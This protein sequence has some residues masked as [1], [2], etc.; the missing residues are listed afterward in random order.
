VRHLTGRAA[1]LEALTRALSP[2]SGTGTVVISALA[3]TTGF[4]KTALAVH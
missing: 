4:A 1:E 2:A 3:G